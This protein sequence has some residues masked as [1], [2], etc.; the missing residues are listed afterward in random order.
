MCPRVLYWELFDT[1]VYCLKAKK[2]QTWLPWQRWRGTHYFPACE[3]TVAT[4][5]KSPQKLMEPISFSAHHLVTR[6]CISEIQI[7]YFMVDQVCMSESNRRGFLCF[8]NDSLCNTSAIPKNASILACAALALAATWITKLR[9]SIDH[10]WFQ[11]LINKVFHLSNHCVNLTRIMLR[12]FL[13][14]QSWPV[15]VL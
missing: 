4:F 11:S 2:Q 5:D 10:R 8:C 15:G 14:R 13:I 12:G 6:T 9:C 7:N 3:T 1:K